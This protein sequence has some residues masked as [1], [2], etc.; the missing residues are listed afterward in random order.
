M[1]YQLLIKMMIEA[2]G[3]TQSHEEKEGI[4][5]ALFQL[6]Q[7]YMGHDKVSLSSMIEELSGNTGHLVHNESNIQYAGELEDLDLGSSDGF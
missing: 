2:L 1:D 7:P 6:V 4:K 3:N 5:N